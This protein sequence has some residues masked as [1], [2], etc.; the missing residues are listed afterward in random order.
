MSA[1]QYVARIDSSGAM[2][3]T[4]SIH[5]VG[6]WMTGSVFKNT[7]GSTIGAFDQDGNL[8]IKGAVY[9]GQTL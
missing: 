3:V 2:L 8:L 5:L 6:A 7:A 9:E 4:G 1:E